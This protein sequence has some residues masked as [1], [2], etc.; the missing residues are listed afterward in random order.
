MTNCLACNSETKNSKF[1]CRSC[2]NSFNN[3]LVPKRKLKRVCFIT[4]CGCVVKS[5]RHTRCERHWDE[6]L[7]SRHSLKTLAEFR[8]LASVKGKHRSWSN[9]HIRAHGR[10]Q[11][12]QLLKL[13]CAKCG[14]EKHVELCHIKP[15]VSFPDT[16]TL[17]EVNNSSNV[18]QLCPNCH[19]EFD[20]L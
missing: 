16:A 15:V 18:I 13:P 19:W 12:K 8:N 14:Y 9:V 7:K 1:C 5:Y 20:N 6:Y 17:E 10:T 3:R 4:G 2:A 11:H